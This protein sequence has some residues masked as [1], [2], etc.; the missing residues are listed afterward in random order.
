MQ[1]ASIRLH[2]G[3][4]AS[5]CIYETTY[6]YIKLLHIHPF[7]FTP[8]SHSNR[9]RSP[10]TPFLRLCYN[11]QSKAHT[12]TP[13]PYIHK[14][15]QRLQQT[16]VLRSSSANSQP[17]EASL[18]RMLKWRISS[19]EVLIGLLRS[20][21]VAAF[22]FSHRTAALCSAAS[23]LLR[24]FL[25]KKLLFF[26]FK[27][28]FLKTANRRARSSSAL[29]RNTAHKPRKP[30]LFRFA[31]KRGAGAAPSHSFSILSHPC[32]SSESLK[33]PSWHYGQDRRAM[34]P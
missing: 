24:R 5:T 22:H 29:L 13:G 14:P 2:D 3:M 30:F 6:M 23:S 15:A 28:S 33:H 25:P 34:L 19:Q 4:R 26:I 1:F 27:P 12:L 21:N 20:P 31:T 7:A 17:Q 8:F 10:F 18:R 16:N 32:Q 9:K 11:Q